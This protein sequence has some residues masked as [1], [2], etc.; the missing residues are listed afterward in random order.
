MP[1]DSESWELIQREGVT[2]MRVFRVPSHEAD[3]TV[4]R[5]QNLLTTLHVRPGTQSIDLGPCDG[6]GSFVFELTDR[7]RSRV[8]FRQ[9]SKPKDGFGV[10]MATGC[11]APRRL[12]SEDL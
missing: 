8:A 9:A 4:R 6:S 12:E 11:P 10:F 7:G 5:K 3:D 1:E 2:T